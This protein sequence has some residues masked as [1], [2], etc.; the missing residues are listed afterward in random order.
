MP[1]EV[2]LPT[3]VIC[4]GD[5]LT[6]PYLHESA[7]GEKGVWAALSYCWGKVR[8][9]TTTTASISER[10]SGFALDT[11]PKTCRDAIL[12][13]RALSIPYIWIDSF[14]ILQ[15]S[16]LDWEREAARMC[17]TY[18]NALVTFAA[19]HSPSS[20]TG[21]FL[22]SLCRR[23]IRLDVHNNGQAA[24]VYVRK[25]H[26]VGVLG[27]MHG[28]FSDSSHLAQGSGILETRGWTLQEVM[29]SPRLLWFSSSELGW[30]CWSSTACEC[31]PEQTS[32][33]VDRSAEYVKIS[34][35]PLL[36]QNII[37]DWLATWRTLVH[38]FTKRTLTVQKD[39][40]PAISGLASALKTHID[41]DYLAGL[42]ESDLATQLLWASSWSA[43]NANP[44]LLPLEDGYAP[45]W[46]WA[47]VSGAV[48]FLEVRHPRFSLTWEILSV[49]FRPLGLDPFTRGEGSITVAGNLLQ[50]RWADGNLLWDLPADDGV[51]IENVSFCAVDSILMDPRAE[52][53]DQKAMADKRLSF[54]V[55]GLSMK[56]SKSSEPDVPLFCN[57]LLL[58]HLPGKRA[59]TR[60]GFAEPHFD[61]PG[62]EGSWAVWEE[63]CTRK[64]IDIV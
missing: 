7:S 37:I 43:F 47:S 51:C 32:D 42:W 59:F 11:L 27:F 57:G 28:Y 19:L 35:S 25:R 1:A 5:T 40:L 38:E 13:A 53:R 6:D 4:V 20:D 49:R 24:A 22:P 56:N 10:K 12:V 17:Y 2:E 58:E 9:M 48:R 62:T 41:S 60:L 61:E 31:D 44:S 55:A 8:T 34:S 54:L 36:D 29:L 14:C 18:E 26:D 64:R 45:S 39:R 33:F 30:S 15:D 50:V 21:L 3:R 16:P 52:I 46:S 63:R 23:T